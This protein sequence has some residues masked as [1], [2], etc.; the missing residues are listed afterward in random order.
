MNRWLLKLFLA[1]FA[2]L[3][4]YETTAVVQAESKVRD[5]FADALKTQ[6]DGIALK[7]M[8][9]QRL[10]QLL[11]IEDPNFYQHR[12]VDF[13]TPGA[14][15][16]TMTQGMVKYLFFEDFEP[17]FAKIE[18]TLIAWLVVDRYISK[19]DQLTVFLNTVY[20]GSIDGREV[21]GFTAAAREY[22]NKRF[23]QLTDDEY[24]ALVAMI[25]APDGYSV[26]YKPEKNRGRVER[27]KAVLSGRYQP[28]GLRDVFYDQG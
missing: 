11:T 6:V 27:L 12:G 20:L 15:L 17:G 18:Q 24:L 23:D 10:Q 8:P 13:S 3:A 25:I 14:G 26:R 4:V 5:V 2:L 9:P 19:E 21:R 22:F 7:D 28:K 1:G 16:T